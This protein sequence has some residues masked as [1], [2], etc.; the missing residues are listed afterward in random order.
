M[1]S[2][3]SVITVF[4]VTFFGALVYLTISE[5]E[6]ASPGQHVASADDME[7]DW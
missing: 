3:G 1:N 7:G 4:L 6:L 2:I 5:T